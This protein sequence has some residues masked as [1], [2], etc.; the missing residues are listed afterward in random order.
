MKFE[1]IKVGDVVYINK[2]VKYGYR[3]EEPFFVTV[4]VIRVT[5]KQFVIE[6]DRRFRKQGDEIGVRS[7]GYAYNLNDLSYE[8]SL[9]GETVTDQT[10]ERANFVQRLELEKKVNKM[11]ENLALAPN[12]GV[13]TESLLEIKRKLNEIDELI[14]ADWTEKN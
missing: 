9:S 5:D 2:P 11:F 14:N 3:Q 8:Y 12:S 7:C 1:N 4:K 6:G 13:S 10:K